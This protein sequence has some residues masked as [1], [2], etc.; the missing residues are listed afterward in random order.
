[1]G[2]QLKYGTAGATGG[3]WSSQSGTLQPGYQESWHEPRWSWQARSPKT[4][5]DKQRFVSMWSWGCRVA[6][7]G[8]GTDGDPLVGRGLHS[9]NGYEPFSCDGEGSQFKNRIVG[10]CLDSSDVPVAGAIVQ[11]FVTATDAYVGE[12]QSN[13]DGV[14]ILMTE[15]LTSTPHY[16]V[17]YKP[18]SP[19]TAGTT[20]NTLLPTAS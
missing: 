10:T 9:G 15:R 8:G 4:W 18:G 11:G 12:V 17:A 20:V 1:M 16:L 14:Y 2:A 19:D 5:R 7:S 3:G 6:G 13:T